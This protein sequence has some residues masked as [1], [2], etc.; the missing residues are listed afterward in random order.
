MI[1]QSIIPG[2]LNNSDLSSLAE[3]G[4]VDDKKTIVATE[5]FHEKM[6]KLADSL[7]I[8]VNKVKDQSNGKSLEIAGSV[9][10]KGI[11]GSDKRNYL[12]DLQGLVPRDANFI[13]DEYHACL[14]RPELVSIY[15]RSMNMEYASEHIK[16]FA[17]KFD[18][19]RAASEPK[20][21]EGK[22]LTN[23]QKTQI[24]SMRQQGNIKKLQE[25][26]RL[27]SE[28][29]QFKFNVNVF[30][31]K[32]TLDMTKAEIEAEEKNVKKLSEYINEK[33]IPNIVMDLK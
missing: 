7:A 13:G 29:P 14:V 28:A 30:K 5:Q 21:E 2:I 25:V 3:Y 31:S 17:E 26:E 20:A 12:V 1:C 19:E 6:L 8:K 23:E 9:E 24:A 15:Q 16:P 10:V 11:K 18:A 27:I 32:V 22:E 33:S 4:C